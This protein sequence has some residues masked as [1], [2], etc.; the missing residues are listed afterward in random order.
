MNWGCKS[1]S[2]DWEWAHVSA[3]F[4]SVCVCV[5]KSG[6]M[7]V[8]MRACS[9]CRSEKTRWLFRTVYWS[10]NVVHTVPCSSHY[11]IISL[12]IFNMRI[13]VQCAKALL[14]KT[15]SEGH[16]YHSAMDVVIILREITFNKRETETEPERLWRHTWIANEREKWVYVLMWENVNWIDYTRLARRYGELTFFHPFDLVRIRIRLHVWIFRLSGTHTHTQYTAN[17]KWERACV[18]SRYRE[19]EWVDRVRALNLYKRV[20]ENIRVSEREPEWERLSIVDFFATRAALW[21]LL[22]CCEA[23]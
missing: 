18:C 2:I 23:G 20:N 5:S 4:G 8:C 1:W 6:C 15:F 3:I 10:H 17:I 21:H 14:T 12:W 19:R 9:C 16:T 13:L 11:D 7:C 22:S